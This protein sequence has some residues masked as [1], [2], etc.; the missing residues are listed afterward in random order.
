MSGFV[1]QSSWTQKICLLKTTKRS[2][3]SPETGVLPVLVFYIE[4][5]LQKW[6]NMIFMKRFVALN[7]I[8]PN[9]WFKNQIFW[10]ISPFF[11]F[12]YINHKEFPTFVMCSFAFTCIAAAGRCS[13][14]LLP[15]SCHKDAAEFPLSILKRCFSHL[16]FTLSVFVYWLL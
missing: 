16:F 2:K 7:W 8:I 1:R 15:L 5:Q 13:D 6:K 10:Y 14:G 12:R 3:P 4:V 9:L 11:S